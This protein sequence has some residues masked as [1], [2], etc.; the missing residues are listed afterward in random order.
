MQFMTLV[1]DCT[2][3][4]KSK[5]VGLGDGMTAGFHTWHRRSD[6]VCIQFL[7]LIDKSEADAL[8]RFHIMSI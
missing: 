7:L 6:V 2:L 3:S 5:I 8:H 4:T 1:T